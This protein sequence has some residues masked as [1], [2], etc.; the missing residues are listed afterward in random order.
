MS[1]V[2]WWVGPLYLV[3]SAAIVVL[4]VGFAT[5]FDQGKRDRAARA[6]SSGRECQPRPAAEATAGRPAT[7]DG[8]EDR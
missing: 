7:T 8:G 1:V 4:A 5:L 6:A 2:A 3:H